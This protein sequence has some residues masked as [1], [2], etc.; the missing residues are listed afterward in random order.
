MKNKKETI[1]FLESCLNKRLEKETIL[2][3]YDLLFINKIIYFV[4]FNNQSKFTNFKMYIYADKKLY[5]L[6]EITGYF[7][8]IL[9]NNP[10]QEKELYRDLD[11]SKNKMTCFHFLN[12]LVS[13]L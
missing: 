5:V 10:Y 3:L 2:Y 11:K 9:C 4:C 13:E 8:M 1:M 12:I 6:F 7:I